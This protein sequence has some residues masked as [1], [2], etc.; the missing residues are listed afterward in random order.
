MHFLKAFLVL[1]ILFFAA[2]INTR[3]YYC[4]MGMS[5]SIVP[6][7]QTTCKDEFG[8]G[9]SFF[10]EQIGGYGDNAEVEQTSKILDIDLSIFQDIDYDPEDKDELE[11]HWHN[12]DT[13]TSI[14]DTFILKIETYPDFHKKVIHNP[15]KQQQDDQI[16]KIIY[17]EDMRK[18]TRLLEELEKKPFYYFPP[19]YGYL[20]EGRLLKDLKSLRKTL[21]CYKKSGVSKVR[22]EYA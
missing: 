4:V 6:D 1:N 21:E 19:D 13:F 3:D 16:S 22:L 15:N 9:L 14:V 11:R 20:K 18:A 5:Y 2:K 10:F 12:L 8:N 7:K 17:M